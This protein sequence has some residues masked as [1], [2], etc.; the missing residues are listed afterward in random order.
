MNAK[1]I[2]TSITQS[3]HKKKFLTQ[4]I[5]HEKIPRSKKYHTSSYLKIRLPNLDKKNDEI[6]SNFNN[7]SS[8]NLKKSYLLFNNCEKNLKENLIGK[9]IQ[10]T[11]EERRSSFDNCNHDLIFDVGKNFFN[12]FPHNNIDKLLLNIKNHKILEKD[13][14]V[15]DF[16]LRLN[17]MRKKT[18]SRI[19]K[20]KIHRIKARFNF[21]KVV[22]IVL[23]G[24]KNFK[25]KI[26]LN[27]KKKF[28]KMKSY[29]RRNTWDG[30][31]E[32]K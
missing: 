2:D 26:A 28:K 6:C 14:N 18:N 19:K 4:N 5:V 23:T 9:N 29:L 27:K 15:I 1:I 16:N 3:R 31:N 32:K 22:N 20:K 10:T 17:S 21:K 30:F 12:Y 13:E 8:T 25:L 11:N 7:K 24:I